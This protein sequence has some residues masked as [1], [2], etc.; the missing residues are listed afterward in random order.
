MASIKSAI[1]YGFR[2][3]ASALLT[4][5]AWT[6][7]LSWLSDLTL[8]TVLIA[9]YGLVF[10]LLGRSMFTTLLGMEGSK[11]ADSLPLRLAR[12]IKRKVSPPLSWLWERL[13]GAV[14]KRT[15]RVILLLELAIIAQLV[16][17]IWDFLMFYLKLI[18]LLGT[19]GF[20]QL[21]ASIA[22]DGVN[23][24]RG[25]GWLTLPIAAWILFSI[26]QNT[27][28][29]RLRAM[30][31]EN[32][33]VAEGLKVATL[34]TGQAGIGKT[35]M[36]TS[37]ALDREGQ[38]REGL[39]AIIKKYRSAF[40][41]FDWVAVEAYVG[42]HC[43]REGKDTWTR[44][45]LR[46]KIEKMAADG[47]LF[48]TDPE[49]T[50]P[51]FDGAR[52]VGI[53]EAVSS[54]AESFFLYATGLPMLSSNYPVGFRD[55]LIE[56][57]FPLYTGS[58]AYLA[59]GTHPQ[60]DMAMYSADADFDTRRLKVRLGKDKSSPGKLD[61][62]VEAYTEIDKERGNRFDHSGLKGTD[63]VA[64]Q[65]NDGFNW[66]LKLSRHMFTI[67]GTPFCCVLFDT[68]RPD[69]VNADLRESCEDQLTILSR[70]N[71][72]VSI[73][74]WDLQEWVLEA[75]EKPLDGFY[76][77]MR[78]KSPRRTLVMVIAGRVSAFIRR[79]LVRMHGSYGYQTCHVSHESGGV[80]SVGGERN[81][82]AYYLINRR[83]RSGIYR[84]DCYRGIMD[85][86]QEFLR[87][88]H[89]EA[90]RFQNTDL[91]P[92]DLVDQKSYF[93]KNLI[94]D[95]GGLRLELKEGKKEE[96]DA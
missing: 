66:S 95:V 86:R 13:S 30:Q 41:R 83:L 28:I 82:E 62:G 88:G 1:H 48:G 90:R 93:V 63:E 34:V 5:D 33:D 22:V 72:E 16:F 44:S 18:F 79:H 37:L 76:W 19:D 92:A 87:S 9:A 7:N 60:G 78:N 94:K 8:W 80:G 10:F 21:V 75:L 51:F 96:K 77:Q 31:S 55:N 57:H 52:E 73:P 39:F 35:S 40:P 85:K 29:S 11:T 49:Q 36:M 32:E 47:N 46:A 59:K 26:G 61:G 23:I 27:A 54:Y 50:P 15:F 45:Q 74:F 24:V 14:G 69:S 17:P 58:D 84:T 12:K 81:V 65:I 20:L 56:G 89:M 43:L 64:N 38:L 42:D 71:E 4:A 2:F 67:D 68:Q 3:Y 6:D 25:F 53:T 91:S 70:G